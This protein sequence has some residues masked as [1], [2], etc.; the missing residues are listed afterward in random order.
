MAI[1]WIITI[2]NQGFIRFSFM[3]F[4]DSILTLDGSKT[5]GVETTIDLK[6]FV[7]DQS[8]KTLDNDHNL[9]IIFFVVV[10]CLIS[11]KLPQ[12]ETKYHFSKQNK[13][14]N[15]Y[16]LIF[17]LFLCYANRC[18]TEPVSLLLLN[19]SNKINILNIKKKSL[20][21]NQINYWTNK[22]MYRLSHRWNKETWS[23]LKYCRRKNGLFFICY[24]EENEQRQ[25]LF[26]ISYNYFTYQ[27]TLIDLSNQNVKK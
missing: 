14:K 27:I 7:F 26:C 1:I 18:V 9:E 24:F 19:Y 13:E 17:T 11:L 12:F 4:I 23:R 2:D 10:Y 22:N 3:I 25:L 6:I 5:E 8:C 20:I 16:H 21:F 15:Y